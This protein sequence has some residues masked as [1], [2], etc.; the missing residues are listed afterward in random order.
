MDGTRLCGAS[1][2]VRCLPETRA[3]TIPTGRPWA[4]V[5]RPPNGR[6]SSGSAFIGIDLAAQPPDPMSVGPQESHRVQH[7]TSAV[8]I[9][10]AADW[11]PHAPREA[12]NKPHTIHAI[13]NPRRPTS[14]RYRCDLGWPPLPHKQMAER[15]SGMVTTLAVPQNVGRQQIGAATPIYTRAVRFTCV[16]LNRAFCLPPPAIHGRRR[17]RMRLEIERIAARRMSEPAFDWPPRLR[18][19][20]GS[21]T[22]SAG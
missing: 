21:R 14:L 18:Q 6:G 16:V 1:W 13:P 5:L 20:E 17:D 9:G 22:S 12:S 3:A 4:D 15:R 2:A 7:F 11:R 8:P 10:A 19:Q